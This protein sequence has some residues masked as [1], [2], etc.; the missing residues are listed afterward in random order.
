MGGAGR[1]QQAGGQRGAMAGP[2][3]AGQAGVPGLYRAT[4]AGGYTLS[5][6]VADAVT[7]EAREFW[8]NQ[9]DDRSFPNIN[10]IEWA[11]DHVIFQAEPEE[12]IR[13]Y[14]VSVGGRSRG[15]HR[16]DA[17]RRHGREHRAVE[18]RAHAVL[19]HERRRHRSAPCLE[20]ADSRRRGRA[21][22]E[23]RRDRNVPG[24]PR[25]G[26]ARRDAERHLAAAAVRGPRPGVR[27]RGEGHLPDAPGG[28]SPRP[29]RRAAERHAQ[30]RGRAPVQQPAV[31]AEGPQGRR[32]APGARLRA[33]RPREADAARLPLPLRLPPL[34]R[35]EPVAR[36][37]RL[38]RAV[39]ELPQRDRLRQVVQ[40][41]AEHRPA[42]QRRVPGRGG[43]RAL[44][45]G[46]AGR[47]SRSG[48][49]SGASRTAAC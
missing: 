15:A 16:A 38:H 32:E 4:F 48:W 34:L 35:R 26:L 40:D 11:G 7:G 1:G 25:V 18:G 39:G 2:A 44:P 24:R 37:Q 42:R 36:R 45:A 8:H 19:L 21:G 13:Y 23:G 30:G 9:P 20:G 27:R 29:A 14:S 10:A 28:L 12:W 22:D 41:R 43:R 5:F 49:A 31:P 6:W 46:A 17:R 47:R 33:R 3:Q